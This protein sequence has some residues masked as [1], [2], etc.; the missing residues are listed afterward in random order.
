MICFKISFQ[1]DTCPKSRIRGSFDL[2][3]EW[4]AEVRDQKTV[5][6][7]KVPGEKNL[8]DLMTKCMSTWKFR[9]MFELIQYFQSRIYGE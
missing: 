6:M 2:R 3:E 9:R 4:V 5:S 7:A 1:Q 8:A